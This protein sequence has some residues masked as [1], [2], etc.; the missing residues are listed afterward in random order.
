MFNTDQ[1]IPKPLPCKQQWEDMLPVDGGKICTGCGKL[2]V[3]FRNYTWYEIEQMQRESIVPLCGF[4]NPVQLDNWGK[5]L[6]APVSGCNRLV[7]FSA[8]MLA[9]T[10]LAPV[11][12]PAQVKAPQQQQPVAPQTKQVKPPLKSSAPKTLTKLISGTVVVQF[13]DS[14]RRPLSNAL[15]AVAQGTLLVQATTDSF[16]RFSLDISTLYGKLGDTFQL[17]VSDPQHL[18]Q[19]LQVA[20]SDIKTLQ[21]TII[22]V[23]IKDEPATTINSKIQMRTLTSSSVYYV[24]TIAPPVKPKKWWKRKNK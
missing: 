5:Q 3:D 7:N 1:A 15:I 8:I 2:V 14:T 6:S 20:K 17:A 18:T 24:T 23:V 16:G 9:L 10:P 21:N 11:S 4:Y 19:H 13:A 22:D 12:L